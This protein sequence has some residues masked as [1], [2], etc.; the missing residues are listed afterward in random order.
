MRLSVIFTLVAALGVAGCIAPLPGLNEDPKTAPLSATGLD[1]IGAPGGYQVRNVTVTLPDLS[2]GGK[3]YPETRDAF[4]GGFKRVFIESWNSAI[5]AQRLGVITA[6]T[7]A[8][9]K[10]RDYLSSHMIK[11]TKD[12]EEAM[13][14]YEIKP[15]R[16]T[17]DKNPYDAN[18]A[19]REAYQRAACIR[20]A[21]HKG[22]IEGRRRAQ[23]DVRVVLDK[24]PPDA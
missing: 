21:Y 10:R 11:W 9:K 23:D 1:A 7:P 8:Q 2:C 12:A 3:N 24:A 13:T 4:M 5:E 22:G 6:K 17:A 14:N 19:E 20:S 16:V 18:P 15:T